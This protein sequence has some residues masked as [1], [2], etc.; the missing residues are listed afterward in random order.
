MIVNFPKHIKPQFERVILLPDKPKSTSFG[1]IDIQ[2][3]DTEKVNT[4]IIVALGP[5]AQPSSTLSTTFEVGHKVVYQKFAGQQFQHE[6]ETYLLLLAN[7]I[8][9]DFGPST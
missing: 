8:L 3:E 6:E 1:G 4:G 2:T 7:D 9:I 5:L